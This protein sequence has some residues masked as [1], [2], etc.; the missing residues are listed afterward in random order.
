MII[1]AS[2]LPRKLIILAAFLALMALVLL[3]QNSAAA[4]V[5][6]D[7]GPEE[8]HDAALS[9][10]YGI[11]SHDATISSHYDV[12]SHDAFV[13]AH[14]QTGSPHP[15]PRPSPAVDPVP[16]SVPYPRPRREPS[17]AE[18]AG[19]PTSKDSP[20]RVSPYPRARL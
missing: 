7:H 3:H 2:P 15:A 8:S 9:E 16:A 10:H 11:A 17:P 19:L 6:A 18:Q 5:F 12:G 4:P 14:D 1:L 20:W 13:S